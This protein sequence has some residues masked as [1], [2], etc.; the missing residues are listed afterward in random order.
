[1]RYYL[2][3][4]AEALMQSIGQ[5]VP[6]P[7]PVTPPEETTTSSSEQ[8]TTQ[9]TTEKT[10]VST[11]EI[12]SDSTETAEPSEQGFAPVTLIAI[13]GVTFVV[14]G[15]ILVLVFIKKRNR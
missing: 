15:V 14:C 3:S 13:F 2:S 8:I 7:P 10:T 4:R 12:V 5:S 6:T 9:E 11:S 1:L